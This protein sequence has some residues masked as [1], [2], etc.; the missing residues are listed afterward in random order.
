M[1]FVNFPI[2]EGGE[3]EGEGERGEGIECVFE[4]SDK[5]VAMQI[6]CSGDSSNPVDR[7]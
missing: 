7:N 3:R 1:N 6:D 2:A 5:S 4:E